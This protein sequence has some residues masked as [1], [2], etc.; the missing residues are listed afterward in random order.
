MHI[1]PGTHTHKR[2]QWQ[3]AGPCLRSRRSEGPR[4]DE[5][6]RFE[7]YVKSTRIQNKALS[8]TL[9]LGW[10]PCTPAPLRLARNGR[11]T[12]PSPR[13]NL[14][15]SFSHCSVLL[16]D[17]GRTRRALPPPMPLSNHPRLSGC[18]RFACEA[19]MGVWWGRGWGWATTPWRRSP[20]TLPHCGRSQVAG[21]GWVRARGP[22]REEKSKM[23]EE[24]LGGVR[25]EFSCF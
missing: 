12:P 5:T 17:C 10:V 24:Q 20:F 16:T 9:C 19:Q 25:P 3:T 18:C 14:S 6:K 11:Y 13:P 2:T 4:R 15:S 7:A 23:G 8:G 1:F 22:G 21:Q